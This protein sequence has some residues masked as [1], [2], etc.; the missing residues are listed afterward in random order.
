MILVCVLAVDGIHTERTGR[1]ERRPWAGGVFPGE[2]PPTHP[3]KFSKNKKG[4]PVRIW[5][6]EILIDDNIDTWENQRAGRLTL[7]FGGLLSP[8]RAC[9]AT[10]GAKRR[11]HPPDER[12]EGV[13][14]VCYIFWFNSD[15]NIHLRPCWIVLHDFQGKTKIAA[16]TANNDGWPCKRLML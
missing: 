12:K 15:W 16:I 14:D 4:D 11:L 13:A 8:G 1:T 5:L 9:L 3:R 10:T 6:K 2:P 7:F